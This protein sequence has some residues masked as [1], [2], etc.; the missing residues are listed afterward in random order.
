MAILQYF[1][2]SRWDKAFANIYHNGA[3]VIHPSHVRQNGNENG[4]GSNVAEEMVMARG[5][6][7]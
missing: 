1:P 6:S 2:Y 5:M 3:T 4:F 7:Q